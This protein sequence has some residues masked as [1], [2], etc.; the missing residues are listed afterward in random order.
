MSNYIWMAERHILY[1]ARM[2]LKSY[3]KLWG[4]SLVAKI[5]CNPSIWKAKAGLGV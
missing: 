4:T 2:D 5:F 3:L 1:Q